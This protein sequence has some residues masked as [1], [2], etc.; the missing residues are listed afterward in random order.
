[1]EFKNYPLWLQEER[2]FPHGCPTKS[3]TDSGGVASLS[4]RCLPSCQGIKQPES[5]HTPCAS[6]AHGWNDL[7]PN[8]PDSFAAT[9][10]LE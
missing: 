3:N 6:S 1:M 2:I 9:S 7:R 8:F 10:E 5:D 4:A